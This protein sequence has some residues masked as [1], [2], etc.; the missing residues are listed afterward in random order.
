MDQVIS[1]QAVLVA[2][3]ARA[4]IT[5]Q[6]GTYHRMWGAAL[7]DRSTG[8]HKP[9]TAT[10]LLLQ[11]A[12]G[13]GS[14]GDAIVL[15][16]LDHCILERAE[17]DNLRAAAARGAGVPVEQTHVCLSHTHAAGL[18]TR[19]RSDLPGGELIG[20]YLDDVAVNVERLA[21]DARRTARPA[22]LVAGYGR[23]DM[24]RQ[25]DYFD[26]QSEHY[27]CGFNPYAPADDTLLVAKL[28]ADDGATI[29]TL[30]NYACHPTTLAWENTLISPDY[31]GAMREVVEAAHDGA[32]C[33]FVQGASGDLG[34][35]DGF[36]GDVRTADRNGKQ[37][38]HAAVS[39]LAA[40][41]PAGT[42]F[43]YSGAVVSGATLGTWKHQPLAK[44]EIAA[45]T[46]FKHHT[47]KIDVA[48]RP[49]LPT[50]DE[51]RRELEHWQAE[52]ARARAA[53]DDLKVRDAHA[54]VERRTRKLLR[55]ES[56]PAG[57]AFPYSFAVARLGGLL[58]VVAP[59]ELY[60]LLQREIR[61]R[62]PRHAVVVATIADDWQ[63][64]YFPEAGTYGL[65]IYQE[66]VALVAAG[67]LEMLVERMADAL[68]T[69]VR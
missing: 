65:G 5:P 6:V 11:P 17:C 54:E 31:V 40:L 61:R 52:E 27:V 9:L 15:V 51:T 1:P 29:A 55:L 48:Y 2:G 18:M 68:E 13:V 39:T 21:A 57:Q 28:T 33:F 56:L 69:L 22:G 34:P 36:V 41:S 8:V 60:Q 16:A 12:T 14:A 58:W 38:G 19:T 37:L 32:P 30:V 44:S 46:T 23:C 10:V 62:F 20:P 53:G 47:T 42:K 7:H 64:G 49:D 35:R 24:A 59:G 25:R 63:P 26:V 50:V 45:A 4:D 43:V 3:A 66:Q 67:S